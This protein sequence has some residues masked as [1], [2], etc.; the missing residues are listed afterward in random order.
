M[1][2]KELILPDKVWNTL[3]SAWMLFFIVL[4]VL[5]LYVAFNL[6]QEIWVNFKVFGLLGATLIFTVLSGV[7]IYKY[8]PQAKKDEASDISPPKE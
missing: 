1:L 8:L 5:N 7:Y 4:S 3:N 6:S 2:G